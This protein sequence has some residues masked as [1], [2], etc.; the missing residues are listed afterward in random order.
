MPHD[1]DST[2]ESGTD[3]R[4]QDV[5]K[6]EIHF[7]RGTKL[8]Q[9]LTTPFQTSQTNTITAST[10]NSLDALTPLLGSLAIDASS[11]SPNPKYLAETP[12]REDD[13]ALSTPTP[14]VEAGPEPRQGVIAKVWP[15]PK[16]VESSSAACVLCGVTATIESKI[17]E[18]LC[19][20]QNA[21]ETCLTNAIPDRIQSDIWCHMGSLEWSGCIA[22][23]CSARSRGLD[24]PLR[25]VHA[26]FGMITNAQQARVI[27]ELVKPQ[28]S[29]Q[30]W[31]LAQKLHQTL[32]EHELA[33][34]WDEA[35]GFDMNSML[36]LPVRSG[37]LTQRVPILKDMLK[38]KVMRCARCSFDFNAVDT[39][40]NEAAWTYV[41]TR[42]PGDWSWMVLG[43]PSK[44]VLPQCA[45]KHSLD[46]CADCLPKFAFAA[47]E[48]VDGIAGGGNYRWACSM[49]KEIWTPNLVEKLARLVDPS[50]VPR[51][52]SGLS[53]SSNLPQGLAAKPA[54]LPSSLSSMFKRTNKPNLLG[55]G[56]SSFGP[57]PGPSETAA[58]QEALMNA[59]VT[60]K[61]N[62]RWRDVAGMSI[63]KEELQRAIIFP[64]K[65]PSL[66]NGKRKPP[67]AILLYGPPGTGK[68]HLA[69][70]VATEVNHTFFSISA[71]DV[72][73]KWMGDSEKL[74]RNLF[75]LARQH[76]S[77]IIFLDEIDA[78]CSNREGSGSG[79]AAGAG[80]MGNNEHSS[81][82][83]T[84]LLLQLDGTMHTDAPASN[85]RV[86]VLAATNL[87]WV[88][89]PAFRRRFEP[90]VY[91]SLPD[92]EARRELFRIHAERGDDE[93]G[94]EGSILS[95]EDLNELA[96]MTDGYSGN[97]IA[98]AVKHAMGMPVR[99]AQRA[100]YFRVVSEKGGLLGESGSEQGG[101]E[102]YY[103]PCGADDEGAIKMGWEDVPENR[104]RV[105]PVTAEDFK[106]VLRN[107]TVKSSVG[108]GESQRYEDWTR[109]FGV[110]GK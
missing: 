28:P 59:I 50:R 82:L 42:F 89:D 58:H 52:L 98:N 96:D 49:C 70:A 15:S 17:Y 66:Y 88:L 29:Q 73:S 79:G 108:A 64:A 40:K 10:G 84:E 3:S 54:A 47:L 68:S 5:S 53:I 14:V 18:T 20:Q 94:G 35:P 23:Q 92:R 102:K 39:T 99:E 22:G 33:Y 11:T 2:L 61:P 107:R 32:V 16:L 26:Q 80:G 7:Y 81:R 24:L 78:L 85:G 109:E 65:F 21:C 19:C 43:R 13:A 25:I 97:D 83:K 60:K 30:E 72:V 41:T 4:P 86:V 91:V 12:E 100:R 106:R 8:G 95:D 62:V 101:N 76:A 37:F 34:A 74:V 110:E 57:S 6:T 77:S 93:R 48:F 69:K 56:G 103:T 51:S 67:N 55:G 75:T 90:R 9:V 63:A 1:H 71:A 31:E 46:I 38:T 36:M 27:L 44:A 105:G 104:L 87:P 45:S